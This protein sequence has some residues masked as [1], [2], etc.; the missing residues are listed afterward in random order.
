MNCMFCIY[1]HIVEVDK[2]NKEFPAVYG[3]ST[4]EISYVEKL[5]SAD[6]PF[7]TKKKIFIA[8]TICLYNFYYDFCLSFGVFL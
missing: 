2:A 8:L 1:I 5:I 7:V 6:F 3:D 4:V